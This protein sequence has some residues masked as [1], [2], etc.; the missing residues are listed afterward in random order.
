MTV[1]VDGMAR[2]NMLKLMG[3]ASAWSALG[4]LG[5]ASA[6]TQGDITRFRVYV[7]DDDLAD[8]KPAAVEHSMAAGGDRGTL[9]DGNRPRL[10]PA[11]GRVLEGQ[12]QVARA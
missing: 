4:P 8:L 10:H 9:V 1:L 7:K 12:V 3:A 5:E 6:Q 2:R 11:T